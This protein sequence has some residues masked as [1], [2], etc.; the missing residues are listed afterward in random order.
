MYI[1]LLAIN[2]FKKVSLQRVMSFENA[3]VPLSIFTDDGEMISGKKEDFLHK[4]KGLVADKVSDEI[5][6]GHCLVIDGMTVV[7]MMQPSSPKSSYGDMA[8]AFWSYIIHN[9]LDI[10][11]T[12][13]DTLKTV[14]KHK[15]T[16]KEGILN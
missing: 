7:Q 16:S 8:K 15:H 1:R 2:S 13:T 11:L 9:A 14:L 4:M 5:Q 3:P 12:L 6:P 10:H